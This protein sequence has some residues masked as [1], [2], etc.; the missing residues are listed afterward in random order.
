MRCMTCGEAMALTAVVPHEVMAGFAYRVLQCSGC[1]ATERRLVF[2]TQAE[3][4]TDRGASDAPSAPIEAPASP[5]ASIPMDPAPSPEP[6]QAECPQPKPVPPANAWA[7]AVEKLRNRQADLHLRADET[8]KADWAAQFNRAWEKLAPPAREQAEPG[9]SAQ[10]RDV[11]WSRR[12]LRAEMRKL[13]RLPP[14]RQNMPPDPQPDPEA[15]QRFN[16]LWET[17]VP[18]SNI[19]APAPEIISVSSDLPAP[20][21]RSLSLVPVEA[22]D[23]L[24]TLQAMNEAT[25]AILLLQGLSA[26]PI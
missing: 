26:A 19:L 17:L 7:R 5:A 15:V 24:E 20:L 21:P 12:A 10:G 2:G 9:G 13:T 18:A 14:G 23:T 25:R 8:K 1:G 4:M 16:Q 22:F 3:V 11:E 6:P